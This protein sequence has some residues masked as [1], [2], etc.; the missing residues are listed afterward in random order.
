[1]LDG[2]GRRCLDAVETIVHGSSPMEVE[3]TLSIAAFM[4]CK[5]AWNSA[6]CRNNC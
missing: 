4:P 3:T 5:M 2:D 1:L 6:R